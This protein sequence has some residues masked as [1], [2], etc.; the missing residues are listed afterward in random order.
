M[1]EEEFEEEA[2]LRMEFRQVLFEARGPGRRDR[3]RRGGRC[4]TASQQFPAGAARDDGQPRAQIVGRPQRSEH[5]AVAVDELTEDLGAGI[6]GVGRRPSEAAQGSARD[7]EDP[8]GVRIDEAAPGLGIPPSA[9]TNQLFLGPHAEDYIPFSESRP[10]TGALAA[11][12]VMRRAGDFFVLVSGA[13]LLAG[14]VSWSRLASVPLGGSLASGMT[15][16]SAAMAGLGLGAFLAGALLRRRSPRSL[17]SVIVPACAAVLAVVPALIL[18]IG[19]SFLL[20]RG[21]TSGVLVL[22]HLPFG[23]ILPCVAT[24]SRGGILYAV[25]ALGGVIGALGLSEILAPRW[26]F[27][28]IGLILAAL[29]FV[30]GIPFWGTA[31][32]E[33]AALPPESRR[34]PRSLV[35]IAGVLGVLGLL[36]ESLWLQLLGFYWEANAETFGL[37]T[38]ASIGGLSLGS[39]VGRR[40]PLATALGAA[41]ASLALS[42]ALS[43][44]ALQA[45]SWFERLGVAALLVGVPAACFGASFARLLAGAPEAFAVLVGTNA[46]GAAAAP[47]LLLA[48]AP[49][50]GWPARVLVGVACGYGLLGATQTRRP[51]GLIAV[52]G[53]LIPGSPPTSAYQPGHGTPGDFE[54]TVVPFQRSGLESTVVVTRNTRSGVDILWI[55]R[56]FQG[57]TSPLGRRIPAALGRIPGELIGRPARRALAI[58]LGTGLTLNG[59][60]ESGASAVDVAELS[61][62]VLSANRTILAEM[63]N[64]VLDRDRVRV[65]HE[66]GRTLLADSAASYDLIV[67]DMMFPTVA[68]AGNLFSREYYALAR[69]RL[70]TDGVFVH[71]L[72]CFLLAPEDLSS[73]AAAFLES[74]PDGTAW[75]GFIEPR[76]LIIGL[77]GGAV[78]PS[79]RDRLLLST[80]E[81]RRLAGAASPLRDAD[82]RLELRSNRRG[83]EFGRVNL[84]RLLEGWRATPVPEGGE[85]ARV[86]WELCAEAG[87]E[88]GE[89]SERALSLYREAAR[90]SPEVDDAAFAAQAI[91]YERQL[92]RARRAALE[93]DDHHA[94]LQLRRAA[95]NPVYGGANLQLGEALAAAGYVTEAIAECET[96]TRKSPRSAD[97]S[98]RLAWLACAAGDREKARRALDAALRLRPDLPPL[99]EELSRRLDRTIRP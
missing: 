5:G 71:W 27:D 61:G 50:V 3:F 52:L 35:L 45:F 6:V 60:V 28:V 31:S 51:W 57:D 94:L 1:D 63:N 89:A 12:P 91:L 83:E 96:A 9:G 14:Q 29:V 32:R 8:A 78:C 80:V 98:I 88:D 10:G 41:A 23:M 36:A 67:T 65:H 90:T 26:G 19:G 40:I 24:P 25:S 97:A 81:L 58:G 39:A 7:A 66:D 82:P 43:P 18:Q 11:L 4:R 15:T 93:G 13:A 72:P 34:F 86:A 59:I 79:R 62:G 22:A 44:V 99:Y 77:A 46:A 69:R 74:F 37:V 21:L 47:L 92:E 53:F 54:A 20:R 70:S 76:R 56:G 95:S 30:A 48:G 75:I 33:E 17:S 73:I 42:A 87:L 64:H 16:L 49:F 84:L 68:G 55:D 38:A 2:V 85:A